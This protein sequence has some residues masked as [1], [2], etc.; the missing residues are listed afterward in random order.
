MTRG[1][2]QII[3][4]ILSFTRVPEKISKV[5]QHTGLNWSDLTRYVEVLIEH[6]LIRKYKEGRYTLLVTTIKGSLM[7]QDF[8][9]IYRSLS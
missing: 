3:Y 7:L 1:K 4:D 6:D 9:S 5:S 2:L 8:H